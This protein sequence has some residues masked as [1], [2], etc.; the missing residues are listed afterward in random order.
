MGKKWEGQCVD[1]EPRYADVYRYG[2][3]MT[4]LITWEGDPWY[5]VGQSYFESSYIHAGIS[6]MEETYKGPDAQKLLSDASIN[7]VYKCKI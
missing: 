7:N 6:G 1:Y 5:E 3:I 4:K 2:N